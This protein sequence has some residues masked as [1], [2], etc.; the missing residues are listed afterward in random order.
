MKRA[1]YR[2]SLAAV[3]RSNDFKNKMEQQ[4]YYKAKHAVAANEKIFPQEA[5]ELWAPQGKS[6]GLNHIRPMVIYLCN[7]NWYNSHHAARSH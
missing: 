4:F 2:G 1:G 5:S 6:G 7:P 3:A